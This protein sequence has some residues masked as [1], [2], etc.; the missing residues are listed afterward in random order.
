MASLG[1]CLAVGRIAWE[2]GWV[3]SAATLER[4]VFFF[5]HRRLLC[6]VNGKINWRK[7]RRKFQFSCVFAHRKVAKIEIWESEYQKEIGNT[8]L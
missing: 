2:D 1:L 4:A 3:H 7:K 8:S 5:T 6:W